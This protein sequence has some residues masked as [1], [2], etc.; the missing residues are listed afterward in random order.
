MELLNGYEWALT[1]TRTTDASKWMM[2]PTQAPGH[3]LS[4][5]C[6]TPD[7]VK[8]QWD[9]IGTKGDKDHRYVLPRIDLLSVTG[10]QL[11]IILRSTGIVN[12]IH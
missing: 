9:G 10:D 11:R 2:G 1:E 6:F 4:D 3:V 5:D 12:D 7:A 8:N